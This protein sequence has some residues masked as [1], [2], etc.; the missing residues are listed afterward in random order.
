[1]KSTASRYNAI[2]YRDHAFRYDSDTLLELESEFVRDA[3]EGKQYRQKRSSSS[4]RRKAPKA[5]RASCG[6]AGRCNHRW[7][8]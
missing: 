8:W 3:S 2:E 6:I 7:N 5:S 4:T 1:M